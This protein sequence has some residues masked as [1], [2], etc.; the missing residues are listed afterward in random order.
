MFFVF[1][2]VA[3]VPAVFVCGTLYVYMV[4]FHSDRSKCPD[5][6]IPAGNPTPK[7]SRERIDYLMND[8]CVSKHEDVTVTS[9]DGLK[10]CARYYHHADGAP[11][12]ILFH[13][14]R[15]I[16]DRDLC[17]GFRISRDMGHNVLLVDE[18]AHGNSEGHVIS[19]GIKERYDC[20]QWVNYCVRR[21]GKKQKIILVGVS[22]GAAT[23]LMASSLDL[24]ENVVGIIADSA[25]TSPKDI[26]SKVGAERRI[27]TVISMPLAKA[28]AR[29]FGH[30]DLCESSALCEV[31]KCTKPVLIIHGENDFFVPSEMSR[32]IFNAC[33]SEKR[34]TILP[35]NGHCAGYIF[36]TQRYIKEIRDFSSY[37]LSRGA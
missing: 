27:P 18:R 22:M 6:Y 10:L 14:Y 29:I 26:I 7:I 4:A 28:A 3:F 12:D 33:A 30:F 19:F 24:P 36:N 35:N 8:I 16:S 11:L 17:G 1:A 2:V 32:D 31:E 34:I 20:L 25:Y 23:V 13:G 37:V 15:S 9:H 5:P 21:F